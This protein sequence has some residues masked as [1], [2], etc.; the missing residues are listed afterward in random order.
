MQVTMCKYFDLLLTSSKTADIIKSVS[1][2]EEECSEDFCR[3]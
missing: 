2:K 1:A 3:F